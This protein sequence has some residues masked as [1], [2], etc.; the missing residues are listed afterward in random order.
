MTDSDL[1]NDLDNDLDSLSVLIQQQQNHARSIVV[2][3]NSAF[4][5]PAATNDFV[6]ACCCDIALTAYTVFVFS[7]SGDRRQQ[8]RRR[9][10]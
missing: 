5:H 6:S 4:R 2:I 3:G 10:M 7:L 1:D 8:L 9:P